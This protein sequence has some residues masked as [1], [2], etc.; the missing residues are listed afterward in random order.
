MVAYTNSDFAA[1]V[2]DAE[3]FMASAR[4]YLHSESSRKASVSP[5][6]SPVTLAQPDQKSLGLFSQ[7]PGILPAGHSPIAA[8]DKLEVSKKPSSP[9]PIVS[10]PPNSSA[11]TARKDVKPPKPIVILPPKNTAAT[12]R[13]IVEAP[14]PTDKDQLPETSVE[15]L[16][17]DFSSD[18][19]KPQKTA[20]PLPLPKLSNEVLVDFGDEFFDAQEDASG[21]GVL[22]E[23]TQKQL[24]GLDL[25]PSKQSNSSDKGYGFRGLGAE[26]AEEILQNKTAQATGMIRGLGQCM[27]ILVAKIS[28]ALHQ[29]E[30]SQ[31]HIE[32]LITPPNKNLGQ[33]RH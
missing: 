30:P 19:E 20:K 24:F 26:D 18:D 2:A 8:H 31:K 10:L 12:A 22:S 32:R 14:K 33:G 13:G 1:R 7:S 11:V 28:D 23:T 29:P 17:I 3:A 4:G 5:S 6:R 16:L 21:K 15:N 27:S 9:R 25:T